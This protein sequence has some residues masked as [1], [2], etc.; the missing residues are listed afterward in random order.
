M[1]WTYWLGDIRAQENPQLTVV[2]TLM[3]REH[4]RIARALKS[5]NPGWSD[6]QLFQEARRIVVAEIQHITY[7]EYLP[8]L[9]GAQFT[10]IMFV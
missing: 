1:F 2:H 7:T 6:E 3:L 8:T 9:L 10:F 4:N 5:M